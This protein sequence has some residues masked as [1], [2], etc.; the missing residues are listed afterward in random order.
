MGQSRRL[1][2]LAVLQSRAPQREKSKT[3]RLPHNDGCRSILVAPRGRWKPGV[4]SHVV[5]ES[6]QYRAAAVLP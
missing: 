6:G 5:R 2:V 1:K 3:A 4:G